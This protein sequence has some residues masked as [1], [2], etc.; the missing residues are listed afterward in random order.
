MISSKSVSDPKQGWRCVTRLLVIQPV[1][2]SERA[3]RLLRTGGGGVCAYARFQLHVLIGQPLTSVATS[4]SL[5]PLITDDFETLLQIV[6][7]GFIALHRHQREWVRPRVGV[8]CL[9]CNNAGHYVY[10][11][12][13]NFLNHLHSH[14]L[15]VC[16]LYYL[17]SGFCLTASYEEPVLPSTQVTMSSL[18]NSEEESEEEEEEEKVVVLEEEAGR[19]ADMGGTQIRW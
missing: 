6:V 15:L 5:S 12:L 13:A 4:F 2:G 19:N 16:P 3:T 1:T 10:D 11:P 9:L 14:V 8:S 18:N 17:G 7:K